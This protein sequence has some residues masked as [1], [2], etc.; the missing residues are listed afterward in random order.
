MPV[1]N[2]DESQMSVRKM[3]PIC[4]LNLHSLSS[5]NLHFSHDQQGVTP[6]LTNINQIAFEKMTA[7]Y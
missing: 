3:K 1:Y 7:S 5:L 6:L 4:S 2:M